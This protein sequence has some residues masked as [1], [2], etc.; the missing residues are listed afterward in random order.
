MKWLPS[1]SSLAC[2]E[3]VA[4]S[5]TSVFLPAALNEAV[6]SGNPEVVGMVME[7][8]E[9]QL[10]H[11]RNRDVPLLLEKLETS[12]DFYIEMKWEFSSWGEGYACADMVAVCTGAVVMV[13]CFGHYV[14]GCKVSQPLW[15]ASPLPV[16][17]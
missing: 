1:S 7:K 8:R 6:C 12:P 10:S 17:T 16:C 3:V 2:S 15:V 14:N 13:W 11:Y 9:Q 5:C 4:V